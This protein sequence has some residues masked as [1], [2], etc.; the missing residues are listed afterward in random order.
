MGGRSTTVNA[1]NNPLEPVELGASIFIEGNPILKN[2]S[3]RFGLKPQR[4]RS[5][6]AETLGIWNGQNFVYTQKDSGWKYWDMAKLLWKYGLAPIRTQNLMKSTVGK[7]RKLYEYPF[8]PFRSL[9]D[10]A[11][12]LGLTD[13]TALTGEQ[14]LSANN[15]S[16]MEILGIRDSDPLLHRL[17]I[18]LL[19]ISFRPAL[20]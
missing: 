6:G 7:F 5:E 13:I 20:E 1:Y 10:R 11:L 15:V 12:D 17:A 4:H 16:S 3:E 8:F 19:Q 14:L 2:S 9:S 18:H